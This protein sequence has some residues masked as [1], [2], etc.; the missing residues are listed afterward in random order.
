[1]NTSVI[2]SGVTSTVRDILKEKHPSSHLPSLFALLPPSDFSSPSFH[3][4]IFDNLDGV[5]VCR[6][7]LRMDGA[8]GPS[9]LYVTYWKKL[10]T[11][12]N[13]ASDAL[14]DAFSA[15]V[16]RRLAT[17]FIDLTCLDAFTACCLIALDKHPGVWPVEV[18]RW[19]LSKSVLGVIRNDVQ[20]AAGP[21]QLCAGL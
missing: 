11:C 10:C 15:V 8:A 13:D 12:F 16:A 17:T 4:V 14:C 21:L 18:C 19:L 2:V 5:L 7:I 9:G 6:T 3:P 1:M 20:Q